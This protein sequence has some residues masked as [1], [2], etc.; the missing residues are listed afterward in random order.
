MHITSYFLLAILK[1]RELTW[2]GTFEVHMKRAHTRA[3]RARRRWCHLWQQHALIHSCASR[4]S[5]SLFNNDD[6][7]LSREANLIRTNRG[8]NYAYSSCA[9]KL[10]LVLMLSLRKTKDTVESEN[11]RS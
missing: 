5:C 3:I 6:V 9:W 10:P 4:T 7:H 1:R 11:R 8:L 2:K